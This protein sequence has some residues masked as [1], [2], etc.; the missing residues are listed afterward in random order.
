ME[1]TEN[2]HVLA[3]LERGLWM[4]LGQVRFVLQKDFGLKPNVDAL[5]KNLQRCTQQGLI[6]VERIGRN[7]FYRITEKGK[8]RR[9]IIAARKEAEFKEWLAGTSRKDQAKEVQVVEQKPTAPVLM[10]RV[11]EVNSSLVLCDAVLG[12]SYDQNTLNLA[13]MA[14]MYWLMEKRE[15]IPYVA[16]AGANAID[17][18][19]RRFGES[20]EKIFK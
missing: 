11:V 15:L 10:K 6:S 13:R 2:W 8:K 7:N 20:V 9:G 17:R 14:R 19:S 12:S 5:R 18:L 16:E 4:D 3:I 1:K